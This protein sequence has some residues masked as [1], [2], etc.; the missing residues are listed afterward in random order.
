MPQG[1]PAVEEV[2]WFTPVCAEAQPLG[3]PV[4]EGLLLC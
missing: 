3:C 2:K 4:I 1:G